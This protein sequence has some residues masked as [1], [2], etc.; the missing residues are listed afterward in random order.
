[1]RVFQVVSVVSFE[2]TTATSSTSIGKALKKDSRSCSRKVQSARA[3][4]LEFSEKM[5]QIKLTFM[6]STYRLLKS[7]TTP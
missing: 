4:D 3:V 2:S 7:M 1:D 5:G 6:A